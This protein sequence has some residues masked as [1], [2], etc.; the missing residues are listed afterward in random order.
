MVF[1]DGL[2][3]NNSILY[4]GT[5]VPVENTGVDGCV[6]TTFIPQ[7][8]WRW[9]R[10]SRDWT[11]ERERNRIE[12]NKLKIR[13]DR[14]HNLGLTY[15]PARQHTIT[16][17]LDY[18]L[19][20][21]SSNAML[22]I[23]DVLVLG[24][25]VAIEALH[26]GPEVGF[27]YGR[28]PGTCSKI[29]DDVSE[30]S[31][32]L[33]QSVGGPEGP[34]GG[35]FCPATSALGKIKP[36][37]GLSTEELI[38]LQGAH[39]VGQMSSCTGFGYFTGGPF[40][41]EHDKIPQTCSSLDN[42]RCGS[43]FDDTPGKLD[44]RYF[45]L[46]MDE[47]F[48]ALPSCDPIDKRKTCDAMERYVS[49]NMCEVEQ[50]DMNCAKSE[51]CREVH[52]E[53]FR[54]EAR[55]D[56][57]NP[58]YQRKLTECI[59]CKKACLN[60]DNVTYWK[61]P[62]TKIAKTNW[63]K[64]DRDEPFCMDPKYFSG[65][66]DNGRLN[67][68]GCPQN[69]QVSRPNT[70][71]GPSA[72]PYTWVTNIKR[73]SKYLGDNR[74]I[75]LLP[76]DWSNLGDSE[77]RKVVKKFGSDE[78][79]FH[80]VFKQAFNKIASL[81]SFDGKKC[82]PAACSHTPG[83]G[84]LSCPVAEEKGWGT[85]WPLVWKDE[86]KIWDDASKKMKH[87]SF[88]SAVKDASAYAAKQKTVWDYK[89]LSAPIRPKELVFDIAKCDPP[90]LANTQQCQIIGGYGLK[91]KISCSTYIGYCATDRA[92][93]AMGKIAEYFKM[94][95]GYEPEQASAS[96]EPEPEPKPK[97]PEPEPEPKPKAKAQPEPEPEPEPK[98][99]SRPA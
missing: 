82:I 89:G 13:G 49:L 66:G 2:D 45:Q 40:C 77:T 54:P 67:W 20:L 11:A 99:G 48:G 44:N 8:E 10:T 56:F 37:L 50:C 61:R 30:K 17:G 32:F 4:D 95:G 5:P 43:T 98:P 29:L 64:Y 78:S 62:F 22:T 39:S 6:A 69:A 63:C 38:A 36:I 59:D 97:Q 85:Q 65:Q 93:E 1:H 52:Y 27:L 58:Q 70:G 18:F 96:P 3:Y 87:G 31:H 35:S 51:S 16:F 80:T 75:V 7:G 15:K 57:E 88:T 19:K 12:E 24:A 86:P 28:K 9:P 76:S 92:V 46:M 33:K 72:A 83:T 84:T 26:V 60:P 14:I 91:A 47:D 94:E 90:M 55:T 71:A 21:F 81:G 34:L 53:H 73:W 79:H 42:G 23:P 68:N 74:R 41:N 25:V